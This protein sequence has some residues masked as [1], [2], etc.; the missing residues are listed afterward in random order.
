MTENDDD[1]GA[2]WVDWLIMGAIFGTF[3]ALDIWGYFR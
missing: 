1:H 3:I 2:N